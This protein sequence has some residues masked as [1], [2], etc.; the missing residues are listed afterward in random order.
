M[1][2]YSPGCLI[3]QGGVSSVSKPRDTPLQGDY[4]SYR[5]LIEGNTNIMPLT[6]KEWPVMF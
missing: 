4:D 3:V 2:D 1:Y 5:A 6:V